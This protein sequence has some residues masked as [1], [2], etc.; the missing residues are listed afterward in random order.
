LLQR[1]SREATEMTVK[2][3]N[4]SKYEDEMWLCARCGDCSLADKTVASNR[5]VYLPCAI[6]NVL[7]FEAYAARGRI[8]IMNDLLNEKLPLSNDIADWAFT[9]TTCK[10]CM[11]TCTAT[12]DGINLP[13]MMEAFRKDLV[14][15]NFDMPKHREIEESINTLGNPY[16]EPADKRLDLFGEREWP[17]KAPIIY[18]VG[19]TSSYREKEI[20]RTTVA[21]FDKIGVD[22]TVL[23]DEQCCGSVLLRLG[24]TKS[25]E[26]IAHRNLE[27][28]NAA[29]AKTVVTACA[30]CFRTLKID[31]PKEGVE[32]NFEILHVTEYLD[33]LIQEGKAVF[34]SPRPITVTYHDPCHLGRH[35]E[36]YEAPRRV[37]E[38]VENVHLVEMETNK[39]YAHC[40]G[41]GGG[42]KGSFGELANDVASNRIIEAEKT[43]ATVLVTACPFCHKGLED[44]AKTIES[45]LPVIDLPEFLLPFVK[46]AKKRKMLAENPLKI[47]FMEYLRGHPLIFDGLKKGAV[48]DYD[49]DGDR[50]HVLVI[51]KREIKVSP[52]RAENPDVEL[53]FS[54]KAV[55]KLITYKNEDEYAARFGLFFKEPTDEE[56]IKFVLRLNIVKL[57]MKG[58]RKFAQ[59]AG[60]I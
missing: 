2:L 22:Y 35:A 55:E 54:P 53:M 18:F 60:L 19:C 16:K 7:G 47:E 36:V 28:M 11:E 6:K 32:Y 34:E 26:R 46:E 59:K 23:P 27:Q 48:I 17:K 13:D 12:A 58:Y 33:R 39:R 4:L 10:N 1:Y 14:A 30:G 15:N 57:L 40:C 41:S 20:A 56:W 51:D 24:R 31:V 37:I 3:K 9:C 8:M 5:D 52:V 44:G 50:F 49:I 45:D 25:F 43:G 38:A 42:V 29:G 21:L